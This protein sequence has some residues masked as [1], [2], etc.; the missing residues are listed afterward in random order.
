MLL[1]P[2]LPFCFSEEWSSIFRPLFTFAVVCI[3]CLVT[4]LL[5][6]K[7]WTSYGEQYLYRDRI[8]ISKTTEFQHIVLTQ[9]TAGDISCYINGHLQ[10]NSSDENIYHE[11]LVHPAMSIVPRKGKVLVLG[12]G[13]GLAV[14]EILKYSEVQKI[15]LVD[16]DPE[17][18]RLAKDNSYFQKLNDMS[19]TKGKVNMLS[20]HGLEPIGKE[21]VY[22]QNKKF[23]S[24]LSE[25]RVASV[26]VV[27]M[28]AAK[29]VEKIAGRFDV[30]I[31]DFPDPNALRAF[32]AI[33][34]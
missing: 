34:H 26:S 24:R 30:I 22:V 16:I 11:N 3:A 6:A 27:A 1:P 33:L 20:N 21:E 28:D 31:I 10:F 7:E 18:V 29:F 2:A 25:G 12:G 13:D 9:S 5:Y 19:L 14:R 15:T 32:Q 4:G 8:I 23:R 17:M